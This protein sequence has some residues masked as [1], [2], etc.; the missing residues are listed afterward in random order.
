MNASV[1]ACLVRPARHASCRGAFLPARSVTRLQRCRPLPHS[2]PLLLPFGTS[3]SFSWNPF[4]RTP[5][6]EILPSPPPPEAQTPSQPAVEESAPVTG[7]VSQAPSDAAIPD[8]SSSLNA[9]IPDT[10]SDSVSNVA[11]TLASHPIPTQYGDM[12]ALG[13]VSWTPA[14]FFPWLL[15]VVQVST[16]IPWWG[17]IVITTVGARAMLVPF[18]IKSNRMQGRLAPLQPQLTELRD[19][20]NKAKVA[21]DTFAAQ[22]AMQQN[23]Q[24]LRT[25]DVNP[26][27]SVFTA[28]T[29]I[30]VQFGFFLGLRRMCNAPVEQL[31]VG[32]FN[33]ITDLTATDPFYILPLVNFF[34]ANLQLSLSR[35]DMMAVGTPSA[36]HI[37]N[38][39]R[40]L[41]AISIPILA[42][43]PAG[44]NL[45]LITS[46][47]FI[48]AQTLVLRIP[49]VRKAV[50][51]PPLP[52]IPKTPLPT[53][54][55][56]LRHLVEWYKRRM[57]E[58]QMAA[59]ERQRKMRVAQKM[60]PRK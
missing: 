45:H 35:R 32:G 19:R 25:A 7:A 10:I 60:T 57:V 5:K 11:T 8:V 33:W 24:L 46:I 29:Q 1:V 52:P 21:G 41:T 34:F 44:L 50:S 55:G 51:L 36:P 28:M 53:M 17:A 14:G 20:A 58:A 23:M 49:A 2:N 4:G 3:R 22:A 39:F 40:L 42:N 16:G 38:G 6:T 26:L 15:E 13:L 30:I 31:K 12:A 43:L 48:S 54:R 47:A 37:V 18:I 27:S 56:T 9:S 59:E